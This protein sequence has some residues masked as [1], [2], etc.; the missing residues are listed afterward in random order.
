MYWIHRT[1]NQGE[2]KFWSPSQGLY[3][4]LLFKPFSFSLQ[5]Q[6]SEIPSSLTNQRI[7]IIDNVVLTYLYHWKILVSVIHQLGCYNS[8]TK[9][10]SSLGSWCSIHWWKSILLLQIFKLGSQCLFLVATV[11]HTV[12]SG[13]Q[14][15]SLAFICIFTRVFV[16]THRYT[17]TQIFM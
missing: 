13:H 11:A 7:N 6:E 8:K 9:I 4:S 1:K 3:V 12:L 16:P 10:I 2:A 14:L 5:L 15:K 17:R